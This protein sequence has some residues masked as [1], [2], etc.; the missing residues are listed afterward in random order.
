MV[1]VAKP[2]SPN[3][4][5]A[6]GHLSAVNSLEQE[7]LE[8]N[9]L[10]M[11]CSS[12]IRL[13]HAGNFLHSYYSTC[14]LESWLKERKTMGNAVCL[15][16]TGFENIFSMALARFEH[17]TVALQR[18]VTLRTGQAHFCDTFYNGKNCNCFFTNLI[19]EKAGNP[20]NAGNNNRGGVG[21]LPKAHV[22]SSGP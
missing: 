6:A 19:S 1:F 15:L 11:N 8:L 16:V 14:T 4:F 17:P 10:A 20:G 12:V 9:T 18:Q 7:E 22:F 21:L 5:S 2:F 3:K 13:T